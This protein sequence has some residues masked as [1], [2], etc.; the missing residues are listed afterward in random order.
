MKE[1]DSARKPRVSVAM[2]T[3]NQEKFLAQAIES[4]LAQDWRDWELVIGEDCS[5]DDTLAVATR[6]ETAHPD[7]IRVLRNETNLGGRGNYI[8]TLSA[9]RGEF[10]AQLDGDDF[11]SDSTKLSQQVA[12]LDQ[13]PECA[14]VF[15]P[16]LQDKQSFGLPPTI[17]YPPKR[18][19]FYGLEDLLWGNFIGS[20]SVLWRELDVEGLPDWFLSVPVGD[21]PL[22][23]LCAQKGRIGYID[24]VMS[25]HREHDLGVWSKLS[26]LARVQ[27]RLDV[28]EFFR[29]HFGQHYREVF[30]AA[31]LKDHF[32]LAKTHRR[33]GQVIRAC[34]ELLWCLQHRCQGR[35]PTALRLGAEA[36]RAVAPTVLLLGLGSFALYE[37]LTDSEVGTPLLYV[38]LGSL[39]LY[40]LLPRRYRFPRKR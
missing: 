22:H 28:R 17:H 24:K 4:V 23:V 3:Y 36:L 30:D 9:C 31:D 5:T 13:H 18:Q 2:V 10:L 6:Y 7:Q 16:T 34:A 20:G 33:G 14:L 29:S 35:K 11:W 38:A 21:W 26:N 1:V 27:Q 40:G 19:E 39:S 12:W 32:H 37:L 15:S 25:V 8:R